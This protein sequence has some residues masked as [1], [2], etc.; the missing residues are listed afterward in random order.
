M[1]P[2][3]MIS[4][5]GRSN[6]WAD[7]LRTPLTVM[8]SQNDLLL[9]FLVGDRSGD[10]KKLLASK[11]I[12]SDLQPLK[13]LNELK[14]QRNAHTVHQ[15]LALIDELLVGNFIIREPLRR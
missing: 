15:N 12:S 4:R 3:N 8:V 13:L 5:A 11:W 7:L 1:M 6:H 9:S 14:V 10:T 2:G